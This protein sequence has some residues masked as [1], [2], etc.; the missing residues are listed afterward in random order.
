MEVNR[1]TGKVRV[2]RYLAAHDSG[3]I[4]NR[5][6]AV[7]QV[8]GAVIQGIGMALREELIWDRHTGIPVNNHYHGAKILVHPEAPEVEVIFVEPDEPYGPYGAK[9][10]GEIPIVPVVGAVAN[11]I[12]HATGARIRELPITPD[13]LLAAFH[14]DAGKNSSEQ[15]NG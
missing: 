5:L 6:T 1:E 3:T 4:I 10:L 15:V 12:Y 14:N 11:A 7:S 2:L 9:G 13:K 8:K